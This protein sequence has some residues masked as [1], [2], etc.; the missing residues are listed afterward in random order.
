MINENFT[1]TLF[2]QRPDENM[3][4][5]RKRFPED[6]TRILADMVLH[7]FKP[8]PTPTATHTP[9]VP[10]QTQQMQQAPHDTLP[11]QIPPIEME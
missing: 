4:A 6:L 7:T 10:P 9:H 5:F 8:L 2:G 11:N 1:Y 3:R